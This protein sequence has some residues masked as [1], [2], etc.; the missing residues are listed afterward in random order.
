MKKTQIIFA[1]LFAMTLSVSWAQNK[2]EN[3]KTAISA[4]TDRKKLIVGLW[5]HESDKLTFKHDGSSRTHLQENERVFTVY[6][7]DGRTVSYVSGENEGT[8]EVVLVTSEGTYSLSDDGKRMAINR[9]SGPGGGADTETVSLKELT[10]DRLVIV[11]QDEYAVQES[12]F[13]KIALK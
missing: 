11:T 8:Y 3:P 4:E 5:Q 9:K 2:K 7:E 13:K 12:T 1:L 6:A 10:A